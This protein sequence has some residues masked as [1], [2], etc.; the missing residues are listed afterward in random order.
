MNTQ[1]RRNIGMVAL[2]GLFSCG[3]VLSEPNGSDGWRR[4]LVPF[5]AVG[6]GGA[7]GVATSWVLQK[8][9]NERKEFKSVLADQIKKKNE[10]EKNKQDVEPLTDPRILNDAVKLA[11]RIS[12]LRQEIQEC[13]KGANALNHDRNTLKEYLAGCHGNYQWDSFEQWLSGR[14]Q[15]LID[16]G[17]V[18]S[19]KRAIP[20]I[21]STMIPVDWEGR[22]FNRYDEPIVMRQRNLEGLLNLSDERYDTSAGNIKP[23]KQAIET[24]N[25]T[26]ATQRFLIFYE[27]PRN[28]AC[29]STFTGVVFCG[30]T[31]WLLAKLKNRSS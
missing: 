15:T 17:G 28:L 8:P 29:T 7:A 19:L 4:F 9:Y 21:T 27:K 13:Q 10:F 26:L 22:F 18:S 16:S 11:A 6:V 25:K 5:V 23:L 3:V 24:S 30:A 1:I 12:E 2:A 31:W 20:C 14:Q